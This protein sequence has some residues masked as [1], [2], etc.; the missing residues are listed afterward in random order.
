MTKRIIR[1]NFQTTKIKSLD[2]I[3]SRINAEL[4][5]SAPETV[6]QRKCEDQVK[7]D[8]RFMTPMLRQYLSMRMQEIGA[9]ELE[10]D[11]I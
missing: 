9:K 7:F 8:I 10:P 4:P 2:E 11:T 3:I 1:R 6:I 5:K